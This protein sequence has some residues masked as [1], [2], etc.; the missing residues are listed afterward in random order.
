VSFTPNLNSFLLVSSDI[1]D[2]CDLVTFFL[3]IATASLCCSNNKPKYIEKGEGALR[4]VHLSQSHPVGKVLR[5]EGK[6]RI[7]CHNYFFKKIPL[8]SSP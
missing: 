6:K 3:F 4:R 2:G 1:Y 5:R 7:K 8:G